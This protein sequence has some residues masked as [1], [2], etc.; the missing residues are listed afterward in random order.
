MGEA[1]AGF[2][3]AVFGGQIFVLG[4]EII[5]N[6]LNTLDSVEVYNPVSESWQPAPSMPFTLHGVP[7]TALADS[8]YVLGGADVAAT[9]NN[10]GRTLIYGDW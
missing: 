7:A 6:D 8:L 1:R 3:A 9:A 4:G 10:S 2:A 5:I